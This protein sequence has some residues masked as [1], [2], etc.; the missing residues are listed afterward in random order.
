MQIVYKMKNMIEL[1]KRECDILRL[2]AENPGKIFSREDILKKNWGKDAKIEARSVDVY[3]SR[4][5][6]K[7]GEFSYYLRN[8]TG[9]GYYIE[10]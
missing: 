5:R 10:T 9:Y 8:K 7:L 3:I 4:L 1:T 6:N 2:I